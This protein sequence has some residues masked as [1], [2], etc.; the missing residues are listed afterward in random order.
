MVNTLYLRSWT[1]LNFFLI[2][3]Q[4]SASEATYV[5]LL[6]AKERMVKHYQKVHPE[7]DEQTIKS[8]LVAYTSDQSNS[9][10]EK[11]GMLGSVPMRLLPTDAEDDCR[12]R[13][14]TLE[15]AMRRDREAGLIPCYVVATLGTTGTCAF[16]DLEELGPICNRDNIW[17]H[18]GNI[19]NYLLLLGK[20]LENSSIAVIKYWVSGSKNRRKIQTA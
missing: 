16:D 10:V 13:G 6:A 8:R 18:I 2:V 19:R 5:G 20:S 1:S 15:E 11:A 14:N 3:F 9:S 4:G 7:L 12:L 17:L